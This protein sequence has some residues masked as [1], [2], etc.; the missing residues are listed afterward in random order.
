MSAG[1][2]I[3]NKNGVALAAD[4][5]VT[6][7]DHK[8]IYNSSNKLFSMSLEQP[9]GI[10]TYGNAFLLGVPV[11]L[12]IK[13][14]RMFL[15]NRSYKELNSYL[16]SFLLF[17]ETKSEF[18]GFQKNENQSIEL[19]KNIGITK[20][21]K[22]Y[23]QVKKEKS[24]VPNE[25]T[26]LIEEAIQRF[27][28]Y[29]TNLPSIEGKEKTF[30]GYVVKQYTNINLSFAN[31]EQNKQINSLILDL[32]DKS[33]PDE[34]YVGFAITGFGTGDL[35]PKA[36]QIQVYGIINGKIRYCISGQTEITDKNCASIVPLAQTDV[37]QT[38]IRGYNSTLINN[39][40]I[41]IHELLSEEEKKRLSSNDIFNILNNIAI[42]TYSLPMLN[43]IQ[44]LPKEEMG[45]LAEA[46]I[47]IT[48]IRRMVVA[49]NNNGTVGGPID[50][51][52]ISR[53]DGFI[54][55]KRKH[56]FDKDYNLQ[57]LYNHYGTV[58]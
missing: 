17:L 45:K 30:S 16:Q 53:D 3:L 42:S 12:I 58:H 10:I 32:Y 52:I 46:L 31:E 48:S 23:E 14:Y 38:F 18:F 49:D 47:S 8:A 43:T 6:L 2:F 5:A 20:F 11:E 15:R 34:N 13:E 7:G 26:I 41:K 56:Y 44:Y 21:S 27:R 51:A 28:N 54:W 57:Y 39:A 9:V 33:F 36:I 55:I 25:P 37:M 1:I 29:V 24:N 35:Y 22:F 4:S 19:V 50:V 40:I